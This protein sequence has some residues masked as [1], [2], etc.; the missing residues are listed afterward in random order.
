MLRRSF[1]R[2]YKRLLIGLHGSVN[3]VYAQEPNLVVNGGLEVAAPKHTNRPAGLEP[4]GIGRE[5]ATMTGESLGSDM[6]GRTT[7]TEQ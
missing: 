2:S 7:G 5:S 3:A 4:R 6:P 1:Y